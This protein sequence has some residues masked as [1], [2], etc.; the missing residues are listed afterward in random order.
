MSLDMITNNNEEVNVQTTL[1]DLILY[2][3]SRGMKLH[4]RKHGYD[5]YSPLMT[6]EGLFSQTYKFEMTIKEFVFC[7]FEG[8]VPDIKLCEKIVLAIFGL[9]DIPDLKKHQMKFAFRTGVYNA[10]TDQF[11]PFEEGAKTCDSSLACVYH[12]QKFPY[13]EWLNNPM[14]IPTPT[15]DSLFDYQKIPAEARRWYFAFVGRLVFPAGEL[16]NWQLWMLLYGGDDTG[17][18]TLAWLPS[19]FYSPTDVAVQQPD[20]Q[21]YLLLCDLDDLGSTDDDDDDD[22]HQPWQGWEVRNLSF[23][24]WSNMVQGNNIVVRRRFQ[25]RKTVRWTTGGIFVSQDVPRWATQHSSFTQS[26]I[27]W[28]FKHPIRHPDS[29]LDTKCR[30]ELPAFLVKSVS[31]YREMAAKYG[32]VRDLHKTILPKYFQGTRQMLSSTVQ[33]PNQPIQ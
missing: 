7:T 6:E 15:L 28:N 29:G 26:M 25:P 23:D 12:P 14:D 9:R 3:V 31:I 11:L 2:V 30:A 20:E 4:L 27:A 1:E 19:W 24:T 10:G 5:L 32:H 33:K 18:D 22:P 17:K 8:R 16:D 21:K 13:D